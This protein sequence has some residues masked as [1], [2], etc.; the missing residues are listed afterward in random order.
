M[1]FFAEGLAVWVSRVQYGSGVLACKPYK[2][3]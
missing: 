3:V 1:V 2:D